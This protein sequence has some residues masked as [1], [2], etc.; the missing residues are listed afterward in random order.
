MPP[1][2][3]LVLGGYGNF[4]ARLVRSLARGAEMQ[5]VVGGR[6]AD[7]ANRL[8]NELGGGVL[9]LQIDAGRTDLA[10]VLRAQGIGLVIH[11]A[12]PFQAQDYAVARACAEAGCHYIDLAEGR[13]FVCDFPAALHGSFLRAGRTAISGASTVPALSSAVVDHLTGG[14]QAIHAIDICIAPAQT[15]PRGAATI[16]GVLSYCGAPVAVWRDGAWHHDPGWEKLRRVEFARMRPRLG[17]LCDVPDLE[18]FPARYRVRDGVRVD[19]ALE[20]P[21]SQRAFSWL[22]SARRRGWLTQP[23]RLAPWLNTLAPLLDPWGSALGGMVVRVAGLDADGRA[24]RRAWHV[25]A[26]HGHGPEI[27]TMPALLLARQVHAL[28]RGA[29]TAAGLLP[30]SAFADGFRRWGMPTDEE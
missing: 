27:P 23:E 24:I 11:T 26:A 30:L 20:V 17:A 6:D 1:L 16:A 9:A 21:L 12:G 5:V 14:W 4:G 29:H 18:L 10:A 13:R 2:K 22:A 19:A 3:T 8:A 28:P 25:T 15:A 7:R